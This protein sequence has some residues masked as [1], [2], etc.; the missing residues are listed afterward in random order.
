M[1]M[2]FVF[3]FFLPLST[4]RKVPT[5]TE[6]K[7]RIADHNRASFAVLPEGGDAQMAH[8]K[9]AAKSSMDGPLVKA[10]DVT[11]GLL[12]AEVDPDANA[13]NHRHLEAQ[14]DEASKKIK[15]PSLSLS[16]E[17]ERERSL[18][19]KGSKKKNKK[20]NQNLV[21]KIKKIKKVKKIKAN[22]GT[23]RTAALQ[24]VAMATA[25]EADK[26]AAAKAFA[27]ATSDAKA[28]ADAWRMRKMSPPL[29]YGRRQRHL[30]T[31]IGC[32]IME[33]SS[34]FNGKAHHVTINGQRAFHYG[35]S[36]GHKRMWC[37][38]YCRMRGQFKAMS[39][40]DITGC[41]C[42][43]MRP[44]HGAGSPH[45]SSKVGNRARLQVVPGMTLYDFKKGRC[46]RVGGMD[47]VYTV[48]YSGSQS[49]SW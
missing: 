49:V 33:W 45:A 5:M 31:Y 41:V 18:I 48:A 15:T 14:E 22:S 36:N 10:I 9:F 3:L 7:G 39:I 13:K 16:R 6:V 25:E 27:N 12:Q 34:F 17:R 20:K 24:S 11:A 44:Y 21:Q 38:H 47:V 37:D 1:G 42:L 29:Y 2:R 4:G 26:K 46:S 30:N 32:G 19:Q 35:H 28:T 23:I 8:A 40:H 43:D